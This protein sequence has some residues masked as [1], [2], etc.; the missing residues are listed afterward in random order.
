VPP[1]SVTAVS[2]GRPSFAVFVPDDDA[3]KDFR[4]KS[5]LTIEEFLASPDTRAI[6]ANHAI[7]G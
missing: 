4:E 7:P 6:L 1:S 2:S 5:G 3:F